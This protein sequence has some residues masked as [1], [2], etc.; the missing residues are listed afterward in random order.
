MPAD[1][2]GNGQMDLV[3]TASSHGASDWTATAGRIGLLD[4]ATHAMDDDY[5]GN[6]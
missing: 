6:H 5:T 1:L 4:P 3:V 2:D